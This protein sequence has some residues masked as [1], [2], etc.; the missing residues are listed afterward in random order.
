MDEHKEQPFF[1]SRKEAN[2][3]YCKIATIARCDDF[4][5]GSSSKGARACPGKHAPNVDVIGLA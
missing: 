2:A 1:T 5:D 3:I 4:E